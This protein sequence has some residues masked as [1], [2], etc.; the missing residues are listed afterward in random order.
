MPKAEYLRQPF[1]IQVGL[2]RLPEKRVKFRRARAP[3]ADPTFAY[4]LRMYETVYAE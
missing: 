1:H 3:P 4:N 2:I